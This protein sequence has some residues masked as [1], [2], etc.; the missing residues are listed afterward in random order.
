MTSAKKKF[1]SQASPKVLTDL[2]K[3]AAE[4][5]RHFQVVLEEALLLYI[6]QYKQRSVRPSVMAHFRTSLA[7]NRRLG[8]LL[9]K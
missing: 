5:G 3:I 8:D 2:K 7:R 6:E 4:E 1:A 9:A